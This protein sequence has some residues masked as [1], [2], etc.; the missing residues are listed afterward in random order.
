MD[1]LFALL[2]VQRLALEAQSHDALLH[3]M[4]NETRRIIPYSR[5]IFGHGNSFLQTLEKMSGNGILDENS[6]Y[7]NE[8]R[9]EMSRVTT[10]P[11]SASAVIQKSEGNQLH[12][13]LVLK[14]EEEG[15]LGILHLSPEKP[16]GEAE[17]RILDELAVTYARA[18]ALWH[19]RR[20]QGAG[21][22][23]R[24]TSQKV[25]MIM[26]GAFI[27]LCFLPVRL[28]VTAPA[29]IVPREAQIIT[30]PFDGMIESVPVDPGD[31]VRRDEIVILM[32][33]ESL[34]A[35]M[36]LAHQ[37]M[38][39]VQSALSRIQRESLASPDKK[40]GLIELQQEIEGKR[41]A[42]DYAK[43]LRERSQIKS[44]RDGIA[45]FAGVQTLLGKP[46]RTGDKL[47]QI[48]NPDDYELLIRVPADA[49]VPVENSARVKFFLNTSPLS[50]RTARVRS[51][52]YQASPD[53]DNLLTYKISA[54][55]DDK[56]QNLRIGWKGTA[57][58][59]GSWTILSYAILRRPL[60]GLR[61]L[62]GI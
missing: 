27:A 11:K 42:Y 23:S 48:A 36:D 6:A 31:P 25:R 18:L 1:K 20:G 26:A 22:L 29:E 50:G 46:V 56:T 52:G 28:N 5:A 62:I 4:V 54:M 47:M 45:V 34:R 7:A 35:Q 43:N 33:H 15:L 59:Q 57:H 58:I 3:V 53:P 40:A 44:T 24:L 51:I 30:A 12:C 10:L 14:T 17:I 60:I 19:V 39:A 9:G 38:I 16:Y 8:V 37:E 41:I 32:E 49:M 13:C 61:N 21:L 55:P 2:E